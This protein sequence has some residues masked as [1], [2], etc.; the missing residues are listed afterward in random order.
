MNDRPRSRRVWTESLASMY[1][2]VK[3]LPVSRRKSI[4][5]SFAEPV[6]VV[7]HQRAARPGRE[8]EEPLELAAQRGDVVLERLRRRAGCARSSGR[9]GRRSCPVPPPTTR[10]RPS[11]EALQAQQPEDRD[12]VPDMQ[13]IGGRIEADVAGDRAAT[14]QSGRQAGRRRVQD[15]APLELGQEAGSATRW[16]SGQRH[17]P[18]DRGVPKREA[19]G[20][21][22]FTVPMLSC[23]LRCTRPSRGGSVADAP[24][25]ADPRGVQERP[26][27]GSCSPSSWSSSSSPP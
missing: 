11:A 1:G 4:S 16:S 27:L 2:T 15:P 24:S 20:E 17:S 13:R 5:D 7:D 6:E 9:T 26:S 3:C 14:R 10:H 21:R 19:A 18:A 12:Q 23:R 8:V 25:A 22:S